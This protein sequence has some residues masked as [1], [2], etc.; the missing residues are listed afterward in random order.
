M[1]AVTRPEIIER[2]LKHFSRVSPDLGRRLTAA[3]KEGRA[4]AKL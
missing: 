4:G 3:L 1:G 2:Q